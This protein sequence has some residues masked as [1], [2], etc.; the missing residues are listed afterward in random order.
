MSM[1]SLKSVFPEGTELTRNHLLSFPNPKLLGENSAAS[2]LNQKG[3]LTN[4]I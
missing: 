3:F 1:C 2:N 4:I